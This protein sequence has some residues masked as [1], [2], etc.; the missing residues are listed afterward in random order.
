[1]SIEDVFDFTAGIHNWDQWVVG[2]SE[3]KQTSNGEFG[4]GSTFTS[5][6][7]FAGKTHDIDYV[8]TAFEKPICHAVKAISGPFLFEG[9]M[10]LEPTDV[11]TK[12]TNAIDSGSD[13]MVSRLHVDKFLPLVRLTLTNQ[14]RKELQNLRACLDQ[15]T[16]RTTG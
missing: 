7:T 6:Y 15:L 3:P 1:M 8:V 2:V 4:V 16:C 13:S 14:L 11:G 12:V 9:R 10:D 5:K